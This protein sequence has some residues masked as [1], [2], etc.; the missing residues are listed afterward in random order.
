MTDATREAPQLSG[1]D[2]EMILMG[3]HN[4]PSEALAAPQAALET[5]T[6]EA[7]D[8]TEMLPCPFCGCD[9]KLIDGRSADVGCFVRCEHCRLDYIS[10]PDE[11]N[12]RSV[13]N[14]RA[15]IG[16][17]GPGGTVEP[18]QNGQIVDVHD[19]NELD[20][21]LNGPQAYV[22][23]QP[24]GSCKPVDYFE[25][26][27]TRF[28]KLIDSLQDWCNRDHEDNFTLT[29]SQAVDLIEGVK[30]LRRARP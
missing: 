26:F 9:P 25:R 11:Q 17:P 13:W 14:A 20:A 5:V 15:L 7:H 21:A 4:G 10:A 12:A 29:R 8:R 28:N 2:E 23:V 18:T 1:L 3:F 19:M 16:Q 30:Y 24:D 22:V 27:E 6:A